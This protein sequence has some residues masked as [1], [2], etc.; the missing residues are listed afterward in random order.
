MPIQK[1]LVANRGEIAVRVFR[2]CREMG[3]RTVAIASDADAG[4]M[5]ALMAD[6]VVALGGSEPSSSYL[7]MGKVIAAAK[8]T[9]ADAI[10]PGYGFLSERAE[11]AEACVEAGIT[12][13]GPTGAAMRAVGSKI[14]AKQLAV[15]ADVP[16]TPGYF[17]PGATVDDL[18][19]AAEKIGYPVLLKA[20]AGGGGR[21][22]RIVQD[23][24][25]FDHAFAMA[26]TEARNA[27]GD[28]SMMVE[29]LVMQPRHVEV[30]VLADHHGNVAAL[31]E[32][33]CSIQRRQQ[34]LLEE[35]PSPALAHHGADQGW[36]KLR[37]YAERLVRASGYTNA[38]TL[39]FLMDPSSGEFYFMEVNARLQVE[40]PVTEQ[41]TGLDLV[42]WQ[43]KIAQGDRLALDPNLMAGNRSAIHGHAIE[44]RVVAEDPGAGFLPSTGTIAAWAEPRSPGI[45]LDTGFGPGAVVSRFYDSLIAKVI[46]H[47]ATRAQAVSKLEAALEDFHVLGVKTNIGFLLDVIHH[48]DFLAG[49]VDTGWLERCGVAETP[50]PPI[51]LELGAILSA[52]SNAAATDTALAAVGVWNSGDSFRNAR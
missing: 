47:G 4:A 20:S 23:P 12:F 50:P 33:E 44:V 31:F 18:R 35:S 43:L 42:Y 52:G 22:M 1:L 10:H 34:K 17:E 40:H 13:V 36:E 16:V 21:G 27:F 32:R 7:D 28:D 30:Q 38:G 39:E 5:H 11:F 3:I 24:S 25:E 48:P 19:A 9:G 49:E 29:K 26:A 8:E 46:A 6:E 51:P 15:A 2:T 41:I 37:G 14:D 45:R